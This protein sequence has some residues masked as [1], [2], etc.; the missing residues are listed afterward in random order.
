MKRNLFQLLTS[1]IL[2]LISETLT[3]Q[4]LHPVHWSYAAKKT[5]K[6]IATVFIK[7]TIDDGWRIYSVNQNDGGPLKTSF[8]FL[9]S[10]TYQ[11][12]GNIDEPTP[13]TKFEKVFNLDVNYFERS[14]IFE[15]KVAL[16][17]SD[18]VVRG[19]VSF[20]TCNDEK[21]LPPEDLTFQ[22]KIK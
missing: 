10:K 15:Q 14:V 20:M 3:A 7:A 18:A 19:K 2:I 8:E 17:S 6:K 4:I 5:G 9:P 21:C 13:I 12:A 16:T 11:L 1:A 22:I